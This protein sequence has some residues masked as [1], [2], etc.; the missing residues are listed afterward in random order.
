M[1]FLETRG[2]HP[3]DVPTPRE[4][5]AEKRS[6]ATFP[7]AACPKEAKVKEKSVSWNAVLWIHIVDGRNPA[8]T[9]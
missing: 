8:I 3:N 4:Q 7:W 1:F 9:S 2:R 5:T 6:V